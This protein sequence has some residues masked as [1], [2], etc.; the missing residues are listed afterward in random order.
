MSN[1]LQKIANNKKLFKPVIYGIAGTFLTDEEKYFFSKNSC[2]GFILFA[3]NII[4]KNQLKHLTKSLRELMD[5][6]VLILIDQEGGRV[7]RLAPPNWS[8]Y[9]SGKYFADLYKSNPEESRKQLFNNFAQ[10]A[11]DLIEIGI[12][13][14]CAPVLDIA[15]SQTHEIIK[16]RAYGDNPIQV[17]DLGLKVCDGL[18]SE[19]V[20]PVIKHIPG[21]GRGN[22]DSHLEL[23]CV[24]VS[25]EELNNFDFIPFKALNKQKFAMTAHILYDSIDKEN[26]ATISKKAISIIRNEIGFKNIL[27][28]DD[29]SM[30]AL[31]RTITENTKL[32]LEAGCDLVLHCNGKINE[33]K[34]I[35]SVLPRI[36]DSLHEKLLSN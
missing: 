17:A 28:S 36:K 20:Y 25:F 35:D 22:C 26:C 12:N 3:R 21:H 7:A 18:L 10:I 11:R 2:L 6:E 33:M 34:E 23:P 13:V 19:G 14:N 32:I 27:M 8:K 30:K 9:P 29:I 1:L 24:D 16:D 4:D 15:N 31:K 5:G